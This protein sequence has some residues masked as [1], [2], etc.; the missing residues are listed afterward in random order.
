MSKVF[1]FILSS[2]FEKRVVKINLY[3]VTKKFNQRRHYSTSP[4]KPEYVHYD[5]ADVLKLRILTE[6]KGKSGVYM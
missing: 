6:N 4:S 2:L 1:D 3:K 5:N